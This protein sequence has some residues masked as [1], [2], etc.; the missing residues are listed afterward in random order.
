MAHILPAQSRQQ[1]QVE[2]GA[3]GL[4]GQELTLLLSFLRSAAPRVQASDQGLAL[5]SCFTPA[6][7]TLSV[8]TGWAF[9]FFLA[10]LILV[11]M[12][13]SIVEVQCAVEKWEPQ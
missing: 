7:S 9:F 8:P 11:W 4:V 1:E 12:G 13:L 6:S 5:C 3:G 2:E 10:N